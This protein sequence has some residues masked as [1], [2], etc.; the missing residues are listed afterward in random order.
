[1]IKCGCSLV[2]SELSWFFLCILWGLSVFDLSS[3]LPLLWA[4]TCIINGSIQQLVTWQKWHVGST[5][6]ARGSVNLLPD[7]YQLQS[8]TSDLSGLREKEGGLGWW[9][10]NVTQSVLCDMTSLPQSMYWKRGWD[11]HKPDN[12]FNSTA[13]VKYSVHTNDEIINE[14]KK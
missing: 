6:I 9:V 14:N 11:Y 7:C 1:M 12:T 10:F 2:S 3:P 4:Q 13:A 5:N 8:L